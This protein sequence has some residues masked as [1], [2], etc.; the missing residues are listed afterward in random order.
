[1][2]VMVVF[3]VGIMV[4][5]NESLRTRIFYVSTIRVELLNLRRTLRAR[6]ANHKI[7]VA[8]EIVE[9][10]AA[11]ACRAVIEAAWKSGVDIAVLK[12]RAKLDDVVVSLESLEGKQTVG[13]DIRAWNKGFFANRAEIDVC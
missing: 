9:E 5:V 10:T 6:N 3:V 7:R 4:I 1:M 2:I 8:V 13:A 11:R 12:T